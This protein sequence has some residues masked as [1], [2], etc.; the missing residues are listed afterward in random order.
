MKIVKSLAGLYNCKAE[1]IIISST[2]VIGEQLPID[3]ILK[4]IFNVLKIKNNNSQNWLSFARA[5]M[6][7]DTFPKVYYK[8]T[9]INNKKHNLIGICKGSGMIAPNMATMLAFIFTD[10][11][12]TSSQLKKMLNISIEKSFNNITV[13]GDTSTNDMVCLFSVKK[14]KNLCSNIQTSNKLSKGFRRSIYRVS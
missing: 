14:K 3:K 7:T 10:A 9:I 4:S 11:H 13:D 1:N 5:I 6:T 12:I 2:G 8:Q